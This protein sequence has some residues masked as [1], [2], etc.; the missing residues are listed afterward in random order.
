MQT[1]RDLE[2]L[3][4][5]IAS[6]REKGETIALVPTMGALHDGHMAL[7]EAAKTRADRVVA[8]IFVN[9]RQFGP[10][11]DLDAYPRKELA[12][13]AMLQA[14]GCALLWLPPVEVMYPEGYATNVSVSGITEMLDGAARPGHF[15]GVATVVS[16]LFNQV[17]PDIAL[18]GEKDYQQLLVIRRMVTDLN[19]PI[20][21]EGVTT[22][23]DEDGL[24]LSS[25][26]AYL[27]P[28]EREAA[29]AL[30]RAL[31]EAARSIAAGGD[32]AEALAKAVA[33]LEKAGFGPI[34][35]VSLRDA[36]TLE[37][38]EQFDRPARLLAAARLGRTRLIDNLPVLAE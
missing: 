12:D 14:A 32:V 15:D 2:S 1:V 22:Q 29:R 10:N 34:D 9:P 7:I 21:V 31:G 38:I 27:A 13:A 30:P 19:M 11:E 25:R 33:Q 36:E 5:E 16:K 20:E 37:P 24:A 35:Y 18:F 26:N 28:E 4:A 23:R 8:S 6:F 17:R 3:R